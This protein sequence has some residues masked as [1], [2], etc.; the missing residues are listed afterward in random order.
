MTTTIRLRGRDYSVTKTTRTISAGAREGETEV[1]Y[2][3]TGK[4]GAVFT[5]MRNAKRPDR[6]FLVSGALRSNALQDVWLSDAT[7]ELVIIC[8]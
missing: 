7:G 3:L 1:A 4:R 5:T 8:Q 6:M 2:V